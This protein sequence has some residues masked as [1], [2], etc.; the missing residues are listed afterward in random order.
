MSDQPQTPLRM[1]D[2]QKTALRELLR[3]APVIDELG[4]RFEAAGE[5]IALV[6]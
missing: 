2:V 6:G 1:T 4:A 3:V 5:Q